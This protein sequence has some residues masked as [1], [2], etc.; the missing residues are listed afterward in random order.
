MRR[1]TLCALALTLAGT[2]LMPAQVS[3]Y[4][5]LEYP[6]LRPFTIPQPERIVLP[7]GMVVMLL[8]DR[9]LPLIEATAIVRTGS[10]HEPAGKIGLGQ[11]F[12]QT[13][14]TG[15]TRTMTGDQ[16]DDFLEAR[17]AEIETG[18]TSEQGIVGLSCMAADFPAVLK[19]YVDILRNPVFDEAKIKLAKNQVNTGISRRNDNPIGIL[20]REFT[21][22]LYGADSPYGW[23]TE[24]ST[25]EKITRD[26]LV[27]WHGKYVHPNRIILG[28]TGDFS[29][30][31]MAATIKSTF[32]AWP[33]GPEFKD[34]V[35]AYQAET[36]PGVFYIQKEDMTQSNVILGHLGILRDNPDFFSVEVMNEVYGGGFGARL[37][38]NVRSRKGLAYTVR[39]RIG[40]NFDYPG[41]F[42]TFLYTK[43]ETTAAG[44]DALMEE[45]TGLS[46]NPPSEQEVRRA[47]DSILN[48]FVFNFDSKEEILDQQLTYE[49]YGFPRDYLARYRDNIDKV[50]TQDVVRVAQKY[51]NKDR[52]ILLVVGPSKGQDRPLE[53]FG[54]VA[55]LDITIP[56]PGGAAAP[57][58]SAD[59]VTKGRS[60]F[61]KVVQAL[62]GP[63][64]VDSVKSLRTVAS[65][66]VRTPQGELN[67]K[68]V[69][70]LSLPDRVRQ[71]LTTPMGQMVNVVAGQEGFMSTP[72]GVRPLPDSRRTDTL[73]TINRQS[74]VMA[75]HRDDPEFKIQHLGTE[76]VDGVPL[77]AL[78]VSW[79][80]DDVKLFVDPA[81]SRIIRQAFRSSGPAGPGD[82]VTVFSDFRQT[83]GLTLPFKAETTLNGEPVQS[84]TIE[85]IVINPAVDDSLFVQPAGS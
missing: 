56:E 22:L 16:V 9:E 47:K 2:T 21:R 40:A 10:R 59:S 77:E 55:K 6:P 25:V 42:T 48:S 84:A 74:V 19:V 45:I 71:E 11:I 4:K 67:V 24:Y 12:G 43:T 57:V 75:L 41:A 76:T 31:E 64:A 65:N 54:K 44:I 37:F 78:L 3:D 28:L 34:P 38:S 72:Q 46:S 69:S 80:G 73:K 26:D 39:G 52:L 13:W 33:K 15:G 53:S 68:V 58:A 29:A 79:K 27:A 35:P 1:H 63:A 32:G 50:T 82:A 83:G 85:E 23:L 60:L 66:T 70:I 62:G 8:E 30:K 49:Y 20:N 14:R 5:K 81:T 61:G 36:K 51:I 7:N 18:I 17:A